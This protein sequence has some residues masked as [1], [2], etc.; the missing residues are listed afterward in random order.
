M[1]ITKKQHDEFHS[2]APVLSPKQHD[3]MMKRMGIS[4]EQD[5]EW[6]RTHATLAEQRVKG[7]KPINPFAVGAGFLAWCVKQGWL[8]QQQREYFAHQNGARELRERFGIEL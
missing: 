4:K 2:R 8:V 6:H 3:A 5:A 7:L 1:T